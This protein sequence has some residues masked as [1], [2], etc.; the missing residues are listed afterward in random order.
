MRY[1][2][3]GNGPLLNLERKT[4]DGR[5]GLCGARMMRDGQRH[6]PKEGEDRHLYV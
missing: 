4:H 2:N 1:A 3:A 6:L 5:K